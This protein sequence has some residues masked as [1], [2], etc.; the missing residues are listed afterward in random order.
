MFIVW[1]CFKVANVGDRV[2]VKEDVFEQFANRVV[3]VSC[4]LSFDHVKGSGESHIHA[5]VVWCRFKGMVFDMVQLCSEHV[6]C[7][8]EEFMFGVDA[9]GLQHEGEGV[10]DNVAVFV[11]AFPVFGGGSVF[12][13]VSKCVGGSS[14]IHGALVGAS[15]GW[16]VHARFYAASIGWSGNH[17]HFFAWAHVGKQNVSIVAH[18]TQR[19][20]GGLKR[21]VRAC[22]VFRG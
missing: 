4:E 16:V 9:C 14:I 11:E 22:K 5:W 6:A 3:A 10:G 15:A 20:R 21:H 13:H 19:K 2:G 8:Q 1:V 18:A 17:V 7:V 12:I